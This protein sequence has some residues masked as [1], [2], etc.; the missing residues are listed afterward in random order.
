MY[1]ARYLMLIGGYKPGNLIDKSYHY[2]ISKE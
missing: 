2:T 1:V